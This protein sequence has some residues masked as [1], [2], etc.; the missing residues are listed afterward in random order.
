MLHSKQTKKAISL[1]NTWFSRY[2][3]CYFPFVVLMWN[4]V[5]YQKIKINRTRDFINCTSSTKKEHHRINVIN[6]IE[7]SKMTFIILYE[8]YNMGYK[9]RL[10]ASKSFWCSLIL[11]YMGTDFIC[12]SLC[13][14]D[15]LWIW[16]TT[17]CFQVDISFLHIDF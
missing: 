6:S 16:V 9:W 14:V 1:I 2:F 8:L 15:L 11:L 12:F 5:K 7:T 4:E 10:V 13:S 3:F 17:L